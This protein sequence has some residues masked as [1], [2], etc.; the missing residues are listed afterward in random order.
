M[1]AA[2]AKN[3]CAICRQDSCNWMQPS[4]YFEYMSGLFFLLNGIGSALS[5]G[6]QLMPRESGG[7][8]RSR[9]AVARMQV[10]R[11]L[12]TIAVGAAC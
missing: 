11:A 3:E 12:I 7:S 10:V 5:I 2:T 6:R 8:G 9:A 4:F 1:Q